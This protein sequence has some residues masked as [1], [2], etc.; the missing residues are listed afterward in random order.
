MAQL[1]E[2]EA[3]VLAATENEAPLV[4]KRDSQKK[5]IQEANKDIKGLMVR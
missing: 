1:K 4:A 5:K 2:L 3:H